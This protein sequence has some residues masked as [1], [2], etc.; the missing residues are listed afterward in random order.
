MKGN[1]KEI[2][3]KDRTIRYTHIETGANTICFMF[4]GS[5]YNYDKPLFYY[6]TMV[7]LE[8][9]MDVVH[10][11]YSYEG[12]W[13]EKPVE[14]MSNR[15]MEDIQPIISE[16]LH[17]HPYS[18]IIFLGKSL[19]TIPIAIHLMKKEEYENATMILLTPLLQ[20]KSIFE[21]ILD[22]EHK[23][24]LV[25]GDRDPCYN[26]NQMEQLINST[27]NIEVVRNANHSLDIGEFETTNSIAALSNVMEKLQA[28]V[29]SKTF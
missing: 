15:M 12:N 25:I 10:I 1:K 3:T 5:G 18:E 8:N 21:S 20:F 19:G 22:S 14:E 13:S 28:A 9:K 2:Q 16:V 6:S 7:M 29:A 26:S 24:L 4:S 17:Q 27:L 23:G 11:H